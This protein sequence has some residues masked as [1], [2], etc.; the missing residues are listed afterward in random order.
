MASGEQMD[1]KMRRD[2]Y[3]RDHEGRKPERLLLNTTLERFHSGEGLA[4]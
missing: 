4:P 2:T 1:A 3:G